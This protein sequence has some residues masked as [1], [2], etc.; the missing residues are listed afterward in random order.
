MLRWATGDRYPFWYR[1]AYVYTSEYPL[2]RVPGFYPLTFIPTAAD[3][4]RMLDALERVRPHL[5]HTYPTVLRDLVAL[6]PERMAALASPGLLGGLRALHPGRARRLGR[7]PGRPRPRRVQH[8]GA[9]A[10]RAAS[11]RRA[12][13]TST[14]TSSAPRSWTTTGGR[15]TGWARSWAPSSTTGRCR[16]CATGRATSPGS[17]TSRARAGA[18]RGCSSTSSGGATTG[19]SSATGAR[20]RP[21]SCSTCATGG[22]SGWRRT[23][24]PP[25]GSSSATRTRRRSRW[26]RDPGWTEAGARDRSR[27]R[28]ATE[29]PAIARGVGRR[30]ARRSRGAG[31]QAVH[32]RAR[33]LTGRPADG[34]RVHPR[35]GGRPARR[36][37]AGRGSRGERVLVVAAAGDAALALA[38]D[39]AAVTAVD[40][41]PRPAAAGRR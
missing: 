26:C 30:G 21:G 29:L 34:D 11:V 8:R 37:G 14:R 27:P 6:A 16:S 35:V 5:L 4:E 9:R 18:T 7:G 31:R 33:V 32:R 13:T 38:A 40:V 28:C 41:Q 12:A 36:R 22:S 10:H 23:R 17:P 24:S 25:T 1:Q 39:G 3:P 19:S 20:C 15:P 2:L